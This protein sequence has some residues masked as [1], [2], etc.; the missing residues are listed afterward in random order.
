MGQLA[1][2]FTGSPSRVSNGLG[3]RVI[4][5]LNAY[6]HNLMAVR[7][8]IPRECRVMA[9]LKANAYGHG[10]VRVAQRALAEGVAMLGVAT[11]EEGIELRAAGIGAPIVVL[12]QPPP[13]ALA[14]AVEHGLSLML[15]DTRSSERVGEL[16]RRA[17]KVIPVHAKIDTGMGRQGFDMTSA[18][19][20]M[21]FLTRISHIDIEGIA[22][23]FPVA[24][25][26]KDHFTAHQVKLFRQFLKQLEKEGVPYD[27]AHAANSA[28]IINCPA[29][30][31]DMVRPGLMTYG[32]WPTD[33]PPVE[34]RLQPV[35]R[36]EAPIVLIKEVPAG[37]SIGYGRTYTAGE[38]MRAAI[39]AVGY[40]DG[41]K[42]G[43]SNRGEVL[44]HGKRCFV[45]GTVSMD[46][47]VVD[48]SHVPEA[49]PGDMAVLIGK[50]GQDRITV[51]E[52]AEKAGVIPYDILTSIGPRVS[53]S[54]RE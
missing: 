26:T 18:V 36:W 3:S 8:L 20:E 9:V 51:E 32:V 29:S 16:A 40:A 33:Q 1:S 41:Y 10:A 37:T 17:N 14:L 31:L 13:G 52:L 2:T 12:M 22:T 28:G 15:S 39:V 43:L 5:D 48:V 35:L 11:V 6:A 44:I 47:I 34:D 50:S 45:R 54:Y 30:A 27:L 46:Q 38:A 23:H 25:V 42:Y 24:D 53:R 21:L 4:V 7:S 19:N 49:S